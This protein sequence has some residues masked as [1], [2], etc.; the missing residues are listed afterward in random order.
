MNALLFVIP[1]GRTLSL[2]WWHTFQADVVLLL[3]AFLLPAV[4]WFWVQM[5]VL[6]IGVAW[7]VALAS[8]LLFGGWYAHTYPTTGND[9]VIRR[10]ARLL[11]FLTFG[12]TDTPSSDTQSEGTSREAA[13]SRGVSPSSLDGQTLPRS[14]IRSGR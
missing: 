11:W 12:L 1:G 6:V 4:F 9:L 2:L 7:C 8:T 3:T 10:L 13:G 5:A 14:D